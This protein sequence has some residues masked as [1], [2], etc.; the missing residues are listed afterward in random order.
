[1]KP[2]INRM[3]FR[4]LMAQKDLTLKDLSRLSG[5]SVQT[6]SGA[7]CG[8]TCSEKTLIALCAALDVPAEAIL[9]REVLS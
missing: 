5:V 4:M 2:K 9:E 3:A 8:K 6:I 1:M 7:T